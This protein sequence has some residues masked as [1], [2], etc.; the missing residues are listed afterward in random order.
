MKVLKFERNLFKVIDYM[1]RY[2][3]L[4][5]HH[6]KLLRYLIVPAEMLVIFIFY[7]MDM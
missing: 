5:I 7:E 4:N 6:I 1:L 3:N 2:S